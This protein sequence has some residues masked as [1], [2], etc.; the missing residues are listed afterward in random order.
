[1]RPRISIRESLGQSVGWSICRSVMHFLR[2]PKLKVFCVLLGRLRNIKKESLHLY[3]RVC[4]LVYLLVR[5]LVHW[6][7]TCFFPFQKYFEIFIRLKVFINV[8]NLINFKIFLNFEIFIN[9]QIFIDLEILS[10]L[11]F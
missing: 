10:I 5:W 7:I 3:K 11:K 9:F 8:E 1:M 6:S 2:I 4:L